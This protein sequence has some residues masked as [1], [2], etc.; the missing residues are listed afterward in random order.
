MV[1]RID[2]GENIGR[3]G[4]SSPRGS[5]KRTKQKNRRIYLEAQMFETTKIIRRVASQLVQLP[6]GFHFDGDEVF[7]RKMGSALL[8]YPK[9]KDW[10][11]AE[12]AIGR[13]DDD[14]MP[15]REQP[16]KP[17]RRKRL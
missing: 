5:E 14:F 4:T 13:V 16:A 17:D 1:F 15:R 2:S 6:H 11:V 9:G 7:I 3:S 10:E 12:S 8:L